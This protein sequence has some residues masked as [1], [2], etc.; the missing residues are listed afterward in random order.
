MRKQRRVYLS[1]AG[2]L[3]TYLRSNSDFRF[4]NIQGNSRGSTATIV[5]GDG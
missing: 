2:G 4:T 5:V 3:A 1:K